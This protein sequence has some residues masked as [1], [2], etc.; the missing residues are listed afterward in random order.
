VIVRD[1][2]G[3]QQA[4]NRYAAALLSEILNCRVLPLPVRPSTRWER[5]K[6]RA[7]DMRERISDAWL[8]LRGRAHICDEDC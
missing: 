1:M 7:A 5:L 8:V 3:S 2:V 6:A 4:H